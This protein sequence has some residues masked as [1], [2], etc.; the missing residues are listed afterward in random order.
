MITLEEI[1]RDRDRKI[2]ELEQ[3]LSSEKEAA[4]KLRR[5]LR[6]K[7]DEMAFWNREHEKM[8]KEWDEILQARD[9]E[10][11][12]VTMIVEEQAKTIEDLNLEIMKFKSQIYDLS[13]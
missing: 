12:Y 4:E 11:K 3:K 5:L 2:E 8:E 7:G 13:H 6:K 9:D 1:L 10:I